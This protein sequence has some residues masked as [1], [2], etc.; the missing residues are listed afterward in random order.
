MERLTDLLVLLFGERELVLVELEVLAFLCH[1]AIGAFV[2][3]MSSRRT[4]WMSFS[5]PN[6]DITAT[7]MVN[8]AEENGQDM[9]SGDMEHVKHD[10]T[11]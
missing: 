3:G 7:A 2:I 11:V 1:L 4:L 8:S 9:E 5:N 10:E 6:W